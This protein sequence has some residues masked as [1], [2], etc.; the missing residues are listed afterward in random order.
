MC[1]CICITMPQPG[2]HTTPFCFSTTPFDILHLHEHSRQIAN[3]MSEACCSE[4]PEAEPFVQ[5]PQGGP[6]A[7]G[8]EFR[9]SNCCNI[10]FSLVSGLISMHTG[11]PTKR[12]PLA[13]QRSWVGLAKNVQL[14]VRS[15][16]RAACPTILFTATRNQ[17]LDQRAVRNHKSHL[18]GYGVLTKTNVFC[19]G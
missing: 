9:C 8:S 2:L 15:F 1:V 3:V 5:P 14:F 16:V 7:N 13:S 6:R 19:R 18:F 10:Q 11:S 12:Y 17:S 4:K